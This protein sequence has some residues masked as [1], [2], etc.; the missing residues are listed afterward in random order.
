MKINYETKKYQNYLYKKT[1]HKFLGALSRVRL[2]YPP[3][4]GGI[5]LTQER[6]ILGEIY[7][8]KI[9]QIIIRKISVTKLN[10]YENYKKYNTESNLNDSKIMLNDLLFIYVCEG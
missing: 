3:A 4:S 6:G 8:G 2:Y 9:M 7:I 5:E 10:Q 1:K